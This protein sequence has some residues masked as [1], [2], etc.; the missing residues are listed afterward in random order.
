VIFVTY[1]DP[2]GDTTH[3]W[4]YQKL[5]GT[6]GAASGTFTTPADIDAIIYLYGV[7]AGGS[8]GSRNATTN[9]AGAGGSGEYCLGM[10]YQYPTG[11]V[12]Y[13]VPGETAASATGDNNGVTGSDLTFGWMTLKGGLAGTRVGARSG[14][15]GGGRL[16]N[17]TGAGGSA[18]G[19]AGVPYGP[20]A[21]GTSSSTTGIYCNSGS[22]G[23]G[24][25]ISTGNGG[26]GARIECSRSADGGA[27]GAGAGAPGGGCSWMG[28]GA[29]GQAYDAGGN[30]T[31][32]DA[33]APGAGGGSG[34]GTSAARSG[35]KGGPGCMIV[36]YWV[37]Y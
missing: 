29:L 1:W 9:T 6:A 11:G 22:G 20:I 35:G 23:G 3:G 32:V 26:A 17:G 33:E 25:N 36:A 27:G 5:G 13:S 31:G 8:G 18:S 28:N 7:A 10:P 14:G 19:G 24:G 34:Y 37:D 4:L 16:P 21:G 12:A 15:P 30:H 2:N